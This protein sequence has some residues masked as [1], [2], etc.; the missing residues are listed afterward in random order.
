MIEE[1][2][3]LHGKYQFIDIYG[4]KGGYVPAMGPNMK[5]ETCPECGILIEKIPHGGGHVYLCPGCQKE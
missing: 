3:R 5:N 4:V 1:R 2:L